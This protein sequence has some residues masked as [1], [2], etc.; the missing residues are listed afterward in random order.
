ML[1]QLAQIDARQ[2]NASRALDL[3][4]EAVQ[5]G[6]FRGGADELAKNVHLASLAGDPRFQA[7]LAQARAASARP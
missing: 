7:L 3:L 2:G 1:Y 4:S 6:A 5:A